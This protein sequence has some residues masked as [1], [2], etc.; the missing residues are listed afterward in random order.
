MP[1]KQNFYQILEVD[2]GVSTEVLAAARRTLLLKY[3]VRGMNDDPTKAACIGEAYNTLSDPNLRDRYNKKTFSTDRL[4]G[5]YELL[6]EIAEGAIGITYKANHKVLKKLACVKH[7]KFLSREARQIMLDEAEAVW[8]MRHY[9]LPTMREVLELPDGSIALVMSYVPGPTL[10]QIIEKNKS[11][12]PENMAW[13]T[14]RVLN[15]LLY[16]HHH[17]VVH[18][19]IK[20]SN[21][22]VQPDRHMAVLVDFGLAM[23]N[24]TRES[25]NKGFTEYFAAPEALNP[26]LPLVPESDFYSLGMTIV[27]ALT[28][29]IDCIKDR[30]IPANL[31]NA[32]KDFIR[33]MIQKDPLARPSWHKEDLCET[34]KQV[35]LDAFGRRRSEMK[36]IPNF[37]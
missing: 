9:A 11:L 4:I 23:K 8:D 37:S 30:K 14:E 2:A 29:N 5:S 16:L 33:R 34:I 7:C 20:P 18:G 35:R 32:I 12:D 6:E 31:P 19:D 26:S 36:S 1:Y 13:I 22:I 25:K 28:G 21:I 17:G 27:Y 15:A 24:P 10:A 3:G